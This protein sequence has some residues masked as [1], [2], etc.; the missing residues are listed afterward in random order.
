[1]KK[2]IEFINQRDSFI[3]AAHAN[4]DGDAI[5]SLLG[6]GIILQDL[7]KTC[8]QASPSPVP[9]NCRFLPG[10]D[11]VRT[12]PTPD[13]KPEAAIVLDCGEL[14]RVG[15]QLV[16]TIKGLPILNLD[17]HRT[18][19]RF[20]A[21]NWVEPDFSSTGQMIHQLARAMNA[22]LSPEAALCLY[23]AILTDTGSFRFSNT[24]PQALA[25]AADL[26]KAGADP[27]RAALNYY[28]QKP[29]GQLKLFALSLATLEF[30]PQATRAD[31]VATLDMFKR[32][33]T[34]TEAAEGLVNA[35]MDVDTVRVGVLFRESEP[36]KWKASLRSKGDLDVARIA[37]KHEGGGHR[38]AAGCAL[39]GELSE[40]KTK[41]REEIEKLLAAD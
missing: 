24:S 27:E 1:M 22:P 29:A 34:G 21:V 35:L 13:F 30:N 38:N 14:E 28:H 11:R 6:L 26:V 12:G 9:P 39:A 4:P 36:G 2:A 7:G 41:I 8:L 32:T 10:A 37:E 3:I 15:Q 20:G 33:G 40:V 18:N 17:H 25:A 16:P 19:E 31:L 5:G 23:T